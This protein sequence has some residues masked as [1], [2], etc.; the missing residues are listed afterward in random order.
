MNLEDLFQQA[1]HHRN[2]HDC[3]AYPYEEYEKL[4]VLVNKYQ[5]KKILEIGTGMGFT[6][7]VMALAN[8]EAFVDTIEKDPE[9]V[10]AAQ[11]FISANN[12]SHRITVHNVMAEEF[13][14]TLRGSYD[15]IF[16]DGYQIH[17]EFLPHYERLLTPTGI[18]IL[19][20]NQL[21]SKTSDRFF[22]ELADHSKWKILGKFADTTIAERV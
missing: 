19:G 18:L 6:S 8:P 21:T 5:P 4:F 13:L 2:E 11:E 10:K 1:F 20:N 3:S 12:L 14:A 17:Y 16:F 15:L 9:H 22:D 7:V